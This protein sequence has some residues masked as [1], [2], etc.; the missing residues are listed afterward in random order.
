[1][2]FP[3]I[4]KKELIHGVWEMSF[5]ITGR[6]FSFTA[7]QYIRLRVPHLEFEDTRGPARLFSIATSPHDTK[8]TIVFRHTE[9]GFKKTLIHT[10]LGTELEVEG[11]WG[12]FTLPKSSERP[13]L[14]IAGG[15]GITPFLSMLRFAAKESYPI[16]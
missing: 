13:L 5:D 7:G 11:P 12:A 14:C 16:G 1:M 15:T 2:K 10:A 9:S 4:T 8:L 3:L 6:E